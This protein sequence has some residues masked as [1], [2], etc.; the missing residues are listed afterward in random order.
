[1]GLRSSTPG[2]DDFEIIT[3]TQSDISSGQASKM[4]LD[5]EKLDS[6]EELSVTSQ[7]AYSRDSSHYDL[8]DDSKVSK[9]DPMSM[10]FYGALP[11]DDDV[12]QA[13][14]KQAE[15]TYLYEITK[16]KYGSG[17]SLDEAGLKL[18]QINKNKQKEEASSSVSKDEKE[19]D[20][21]GAWGKPLGLPA[22]ST[23]LYE[24]TKARYSTQ[25]LRL[26]LEE[27]VC[28]ERSYLY[29]VT[30]AKYDVLLVDDEERDLDLI[31]KN[32]QGQDVLRTSGYGELPTALEEEDDPIASWGKPL[33]LPS[34]APPNDNKGTPKKERKLPP[35]VTAKNRLNDDKKRAES[36]SKY[37]NKKVNPVYVDLTYVPHHG[38]SYYAYVDFFKRIRARY[39]VFSG[40]EPSREVYN[41][42]LEAKQTWEDKELEVT[43]IPTYDTDIL[44]YWVAENEELL[45][46][47]KIDLSPS[48]SRCTINLQDH[49]TS[50]SAYRLEF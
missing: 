22:P 16:A 14:G 40:T 37:K 17:T 50:C 46:K 25:G 27:E 20:P 7:V 11:D 31:N 45:T 21:I 5:S 3:S 41:A 36:P 15:P 38:N 13:Q 49:E 30:K 23:Y 6:D 18:D 10:S 47:Y 19:K 44:G 43:I 9:I 28:Q 24:V 34:P 48:A 39:Y 35:N 33:G 29:E 4:Q 42:L 1:M 8:D 32:E 2:S 26:E 12:T